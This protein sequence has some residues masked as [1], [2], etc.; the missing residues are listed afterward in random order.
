[1]CS[2]VF[3]CS[4]CREAH[5]RQFHKIE[6]DCEICLYGR[7]TIKN[8]SIILFN[9]IKKFHWPL[10]CVFC[11]K[12]FETL[13]E[14]IPHGKCDMNPNGDVQKNMPKTPVT[15][16]VEQEASLVVTPFYKI[17][18]P[19][20]LQ[21]GVTAT[22]GATS[23]PLQQNA[24][25]ITPVNNNQKKFYKSNLKLTASTGRSDSKKM[26]RRVTFGETP[27]FSSDPYEKENS[28]YSHHLFSFIK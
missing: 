7:G 9:H 5:Q 12:Q 28:M 8:V 2:K 14:L 16:V 25:K 1:M 27:S 15:P 6:P 24:D 23:T 13:D 18:V 17:C 4:D 10:H 11:K 19:G 3:C 20:T 21:P 22:I 26:E